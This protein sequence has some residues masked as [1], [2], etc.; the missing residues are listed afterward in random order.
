MRCSLVVGHIRPFLPVK[1]G[2]VIFNN[3]NYM[4]TCTFNIFARE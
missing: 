1:G 3:L 4:G 2:R